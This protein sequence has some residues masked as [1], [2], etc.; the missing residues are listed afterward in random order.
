M[1]VKEGLQLPDSLIIQKSLPV[2][3]PRQNE[4]GIDAN[5]SPGSDRWKYFAKRRLGLFITRR[6]V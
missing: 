6:A 1:M 5:N 4:G 2:Q 3:A